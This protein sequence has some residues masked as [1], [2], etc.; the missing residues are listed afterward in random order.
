MAAYLG[1]AAVLVIETVTITNVK[2]VDFSSAVTAV[3]STDNDDS[4][5][6]E[7]LPGDEDGTF[8]FTVNYDGAA[9][10][11]TGLIALVYAKTQSTV[12]Y[13]PSGNVNGQYKYTFEAVLTNLSTPTQHEA[14][15]EMT[16]EGQITGGVTAAVIAP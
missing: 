16:V 10:S 1:S 5:K 3:D 2:S 8:S 11:H 13:Y 15:V 14:V 6:K 9:A 4:S 12:I 7:Y